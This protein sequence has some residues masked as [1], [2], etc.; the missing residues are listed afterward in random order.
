[1]LKGN[2][3]PVNVLQVIG[4]LA[5]GGAEHVILTKCSGIRS[6]DPSFHFR[7][8]ALYTKDNFADQ[9]TSAGIPVDCLHA[10]ENRQVRALLRTIRYLII[11]KPDI[12]HTHLSG[13]R[14]GQ[15]ASALTGIG[16]RI[17][18]L[19][20]IKQD[21]S[22]YERLTNRMTG[23]L[24]HAIVA[25][26]E[27]LRD[28]WVR[29]RGMPA[30]KMHV[31]YNAPS[32][33]P[34]QQPPIRRRR[35]AAGVK[36][37]CIG[38]LRPVKG[39]I[40]AIEAMRDVCRVLP[41]SVLEIYGADPDG[42]GAE[43]EQAIMRWSLAGK[44]KLQ[45]P[46]ADPKQI[47]CGADIVLMPSVSEGFPLVPV[48]ALSLGVPVVASG[49]PIHR[50]ILGR[51]EYGLVVP[52]QNPAALASAVIRLASDPDLF[53]ALSRKGIERARVFSRENMA[54]GYLRLYDKLLGRDGG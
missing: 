24:A 9:F 43:L 4:R 2:G 25:V 23:I 12:V 28:V 47:L 31:I 32:F 36:C 33:E 49:L 26:S 10:S 37:V 53:S 5:R 40:F 38:N 29:E 14:I 48:E 44:V 35:G 18:T 19:H 8:L 3:L 1:M 16:R 50:E 27:S 15:L 54:A 20:N 42:Y 13:D 6:R 30:K 45:G 46:T 22:V 17:S 39:H 7:V 34:P 21:R 41:E 52:P 11:H 51:D